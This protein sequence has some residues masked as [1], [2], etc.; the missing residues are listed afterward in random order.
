MD[1]NHQKVL[2]TGLAG[3][4]GTN[5]F[6]YLGRYFPKVDVYGFDLVYGQDC[7][8]HK[9]MEEAIIGKDLVINLAAF[10]HT[11]TSMRYPKLFIDNNINI[12]YNVLE[13]CTKYKIKLIHIS[14]SEV[15]GS[16]QKPF[17]KENEDH[18][19]N[20]A[21]PYA[22]SKVQTD[23]MCQTWHRVYGT[24]V[25]IVRPFNGY[26]FYQDK[27]KVISKFIEKIIKEE[28]IQIY[29]SGEQRRDWLFIEDLVR[30]IWESRKLPAGEKI[31]FCSGES[32]S[33]NELLVELKEI[34]KKD[35]KVDK[36]EARIEEV[37]NMVG[38]YSKAEKLLGWKP[39]VLWKE[40]LRR[41]YSWIKENKPICY[42]GGEPKTLRFTANE[43]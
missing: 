34:S 14:S 11:D 18:T 43:Q 42:L 24:D 30:G 20:P 40:G 6:Q 13:L 21:S 19:F 32:H 25:V 9:Q 37:M 15:Y 27:R 23:A 31:N 10:T 2:I 17:L 39:E 3:F 26:G 12:V 29:G 41:T 7:R 28:A 36:S 33:I 5:L 1:G 22:L 8:N 35:F 38:D 16:L 4:F